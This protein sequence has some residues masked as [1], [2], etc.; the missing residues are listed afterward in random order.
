VPP[1]DVHP[2]NPGSRRSCSS[3]QRPPTGSQ[4][5]RPGAPGMPARRCRFAVPHRRTSLGRRANLS[6]PHPRPLRGHH[7]RPATPAATR[8]AVLRVCEGGV[9]WA[10]RRRGGGARSRARWP[11]R[12]W[13][14]VL[15][16]PRFVGVNRWGRQPICLAERAQA[17]LDDNGR[18]LQGESSQTTMADTF[19]V[20]NAPGHRGRSGVEGSVVRAP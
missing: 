18:R 15:E 3:R 14:S 2:A 1:R 5:G 19:A 4:W 20:V 7:D 13:I 10:T 9:S 17:E 8:L 11:R 12:M 16:L 6:P